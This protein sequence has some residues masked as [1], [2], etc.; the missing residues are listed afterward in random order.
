[1]GGSEHAGVMCEYGGSDLT[2]LMLVIDKRWLGFKRLEAH[3]SQ[4]W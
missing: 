3:Q 1:M 4:Q 2:W